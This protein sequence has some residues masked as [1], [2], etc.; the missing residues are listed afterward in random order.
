MIYQTISSVSQLRDKFQA[1]GRSNQFSYDAYE[2]IFNYLEEMGEDVELDVVAIC[3]D[4]TE[5]SEEDIRRDYKL[6]EDESVED[7]LSERTSIIGQTDKGFI[8]FNF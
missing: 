5:S 6:P 1:S 8:Y 4:I 7:Y 3:C 2:Y